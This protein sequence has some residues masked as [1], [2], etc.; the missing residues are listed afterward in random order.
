[1]NQPGKVSLAGACAFGY[2]AIGLAQQEGVQPGWWDDMGPLDALF[3][4]TIW[5]QRAPR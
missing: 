5:P 3:L 2:A 4:G 1:V